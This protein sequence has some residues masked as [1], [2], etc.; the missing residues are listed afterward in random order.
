MGLIERGINEGVYKY[1]KGG[2][3]LSVGRVYNF[4]K[5]ICLFVYQKYIAI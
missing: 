4:L 2:K 1:F 5:E 3:F